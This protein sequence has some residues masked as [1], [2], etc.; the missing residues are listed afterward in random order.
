MKDIF[1]AENADTV[2]MKDELNIITKTVITAAI[3]VHRELGPGLLES[4]YEAC[5]AYELL[6]SGLLAERQKALPI[7][8]RDVEL[9]CGYR[10]DIL[11]ERKIIIELK[12]VEKFEPIHQAQILS[13]LKL[14]GCKVGLLINFNSKVLKAG[15]KRLVLGLKE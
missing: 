1:T 6:E 2:K 13:Y 3:K 5:L 10:I 12:T 8:Y 4:A 9:D 14:S 15:I 7:K 11:V